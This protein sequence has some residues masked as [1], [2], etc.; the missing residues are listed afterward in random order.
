MDEE[1][2]RDSR[3]LLVRLRE[4][5]VDV[6]G[7][8]NKK[9]A[10][11][12]SNMPQYSVLAMLD[13]MGEATM[14]SLSRRLGTTMGASTNLVDKLV[15]AGLVERNRSSEDRRVVNVKATEAGAELLESVTRSTAEYMGQ[16]LQDISDSDRK[17]VIRITGRLVELIRASR[18]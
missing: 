13:E 17:E 14:G 9:L 12:G 5:R 1:I 15:Y 4:L 7:F 3:D 10:E 2:L 11:K 6:I 16:F 18:S 8:A